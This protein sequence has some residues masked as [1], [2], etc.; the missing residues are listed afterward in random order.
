M[1]DV[2]DHVAETL[3]TSIDAVVPVS[4]APGIEPWNVE[5]LWARVARDLDAAKCRQL[6]RLRTTKGSW[7][8]NI[9]GVGTFAVQLA[10]GLARNHFP[11]RE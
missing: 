10:G 11:T 8:E 3:G 6:Q 2:M 9:A 1:R 7:L 4:L 5:Y